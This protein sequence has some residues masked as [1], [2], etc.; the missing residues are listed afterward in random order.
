VKDTYR[1]KDLSDLRKLGVHVIVI[2]P[3]GHQLEKAQAACHEPQKWCFA[4]ASSSARD[5]FYGV[6]VEVSGAAHF[7]LF[8]NGAGFGGVG[9][10]LW[11]RIP[12]SSP[13]NAEVCVTKAPVPQTLL[14]IFLP[15]TTPGARRMDRS[16]SVSGKEGFED[17][18]KPPP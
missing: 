7:T 4:Q 16:K 1:S 15:Y 18:E 3:L 6:S 10:S 13:P 9:F 14:R 8:V 12:A 2:D 17:L 5:R 11:V